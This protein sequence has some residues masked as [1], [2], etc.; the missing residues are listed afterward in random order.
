MTDFFKKKW[1]IVIYFIFIAITF[2]MVIFHDN[3]KN[4]DIFKEKGNIA[5]SSGWE[6]DF[7]NG[8]S[9]VTDLPADLPKNN[10]NTLILKNTLPELDDSQSF[11]LRVR[12]VG[13][14]IYVG[15]D[16]RVDTISGRKKK[17]LWDSM[18]GIYYQEV[19]VTSADSGKEI[20]ME[21]QSKTQFYLKTPGAVYL[22]DRGS[23]F[24]HIIQTK[25]KTLL[26]ATLLAFLGIVLI[27]LWM[28]S[29]VLLKQSFREV[30]CLGLF[31]TAVACWL[32][33]ESNCGQFWFHDTG[34]L[35]VLAYEVLMLLPVPIALFFAYYSDRESIKKASNCVAVV[36]LVVFVL[37]NLLHLFRI[38]YL[39]DTLIIT[40]I[41][42]LFETAVV[43]IIQVTEIMYK[44]K[45]RREY[46]TAVWIIPLYGIAVLVPMAVLEII[47]YAFFSTKYPNDGIMI[48]FGV[49][50]YLTCL[51]YDTFVRMNVRSMKYKQ[52]AE[53]KSQFL[54]NM[55]HEIRT[56]LNAILGF[57]EVILRISKEESVK[58][59][60]VNIQ[61]AGESLKGIINSILD[62]SKIE[63]GK[64]EIYSVEYSTV[65]LLD[66]VV[67]MIE[68][69]AKKK[70]LK[71]ITDIDQNLPEVLIGDENHILQVIMNIMNNA[72]KYTEAG[73]VT[74]TVKVLEM[75]E[76]MPLCR[77]YISV[78]DTG[79]GIKPEDRQRLFE[80]FERLDGEKNYGKEG[81][82]LGMS[83]VVR[84]LHA[85]GSEIELDSVYGQGS[86]FHF[87][88]VQSVVDR[89]QIGSFIERRKELA[90][91]NSHGV[92]FIAP[93][94]KV[95]IVDDVQMNLDAASALLEQ[96]QMEIHTA[97]SGQE[98]IRKIKQNHYNLVLMDHM[99]PE[100]DGIKTT[101]KVRDLAV[102]TQDP[103]YAELPILALTANAMVG[104]KESFLQAG[105]QDFISKPIEINTL[106]A[107]IK[108]WLPKDLVQKVSEQ[109]LQKLAEHEVENQE[110][111]WEQVPACVDVAT[112][113]QF[114]PSYELFE[115][116]IKNYKNS[117]TATRD[118]LRAFKDQ[119][120]VENY[121]ITVHGL[122]STSRMIGLVQISEFAREQEE[123]CQ[124]GQEALVWEETESLLEKYG[125]CVENIRTFFG[126]NEPEQESVDEQTGISEDEY[127]A[128]LQRVKE[129]AA[130]FDMGAF[131]MLEDEMAEVVV[132]TEKQ[133]EFAM[134]KELVS[135][136]AFGDLSEYFETH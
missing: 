119:Q 29:T 100:M 129:A 118:K 131:M 16:L 23:L 86:D 15:D 130:E 41:M 95:L 40:Q 66:H 96:L 46:A 101:E 18:I 114:C 3:G 60:A 135:N 43:A 11:F 76:N 26:C 120:D 103:Y 61:E 80:K 111:P 8:I 125:A 65:Q 112:A 4:D 70:G 62:I 122:K 25:W 13:V 106:N 54:A 1:H 92:D 27:V 42:L 116:N 93:E 94:A 12:H 72:V 124:N 123:K 109:Q 89:K 28:M 52:S 90:L 108:K 36:P 49:L 99:M 9:G 10:S 5:F 132:P 24:L 47:K 50:F 110:N 59:Y 39:P 84:L 71:F 117:Y 2:C 30:L 31:S 33:T 88:L 19:P 38:V 45:R 121:T 68:A 20:V 51:A 6:Y 73:S 83:I 17:G 113:R 97:Q 32:F 81:T 127:K 63:S 57:N 128:L 107:A 82:G 98:A 136:A 91:E 126:E 35:T 74:F 105:M 79:I 133:E 104:M 21:T 22:G 44:Y 53:V 115:K 78:K 14:K 55:S 64:L 77:L 58:K 67:S 37:N 7:L 75:P 87:E 69:L 85:M 48:A 134:V 102:E 34:K 56:P